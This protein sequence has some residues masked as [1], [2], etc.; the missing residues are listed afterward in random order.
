MATLKGHDGIDFL[1]LSTLLSIHS[2][3]QEPQGRS[4]AHGSDPDSSDD[5]D[6]DLDSE[7]GG[8]PTKPEGPLALPDCKNKQLIRFLDHIAETFAR[9]KSTQEKQLRRRRGSITGGQGASH[10][11][12][13]GFAWVH[14]DPTVYLA[15][16]RPS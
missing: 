15:K 11:T 5:E 13:S 3:Q 12:A 14:G 1:S 10:V 7:K 16:K 8:A 9:E 4:G 6:C 2:G